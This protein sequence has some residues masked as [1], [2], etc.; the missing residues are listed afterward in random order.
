MIG[1]EIHDTGCR[2]KINSWQLKCISQDLQ[3]INPSCRQD[4][5]GPF[6]LILAFPYFC[7][8]FF[9]KRST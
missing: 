3:V 4:R 5:Q 9:F 6:L 7:N 2:M 1:N 8:D